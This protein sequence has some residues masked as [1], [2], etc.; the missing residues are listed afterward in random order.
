MET[1]SPLRSPVLSANPVAGTVAGT[2]WKATAAL[3]HISNALFDLKETMPDDSY[4]KL[5]TSLKRSYD[6]M[7]NANNN[8]N[9]EVVDDPD[10]VDDPDYEPGVATP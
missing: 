1:P 3:Q 4:R 5:S 8:N 10:L 9:I 7:L 6:E 2:A